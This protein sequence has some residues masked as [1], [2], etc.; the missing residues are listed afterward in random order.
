M[1]KKR[2]DHKWKI[3]MCDGSIVVASFPEANNAAA[4]RTW[5]NGGEKPDGILSQFIS[6]GGNIVLN[7]DNIISI[8]KDI[9]KCHRFSKLKFWRPK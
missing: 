5:L 8:N 1:I 2:I 3:A 4:V 9:P 6:V 7:K